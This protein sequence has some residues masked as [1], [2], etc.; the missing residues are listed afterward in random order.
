MPQLSIG[1]PIPVGIIETQDNGLLALPA[2]AKTAVDPSD[3]A[4]AADAFVLVPLKLGL[5]TMLA[6][7]AFALNPFFAMSGFKLPE[8]DVN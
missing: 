4:T 5:A 8:T 3:H 6:S 2:P 1:A 7:W